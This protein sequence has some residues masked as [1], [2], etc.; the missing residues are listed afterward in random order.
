[1]AMEYVSKSK[2]ALRDVAAKLSKEEKYDPD[3]SVGDSNTAP[4]VCP[5]IYSAPHPS[6]SVSPPV[7]T[8]DSHRPITEMQHQ[9][10][11]NVFY[12]YG[13]QFGDFH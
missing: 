2:V 6:V 12:I 3:T 7:P 8:G 11:K 9:P 1:M 4:A 13:G 10:G 5:S